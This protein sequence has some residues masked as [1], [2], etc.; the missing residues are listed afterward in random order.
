MQGALAAAKR[1]SH[2]E[3][4]AAL[5]KAWRAFP[6]AK[7]VNVPRTTL[8]TYAGNYRNEQAAVA[9]TLNAD[10]LALRIANQQPMTLVRDRRRH[11]QHRRGAGRER[12]LRRARRD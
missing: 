5:E 6:A 8:Q 2:A 9:V 11:V 10:A 3:I 1:G 12:Q 7:V 4:V